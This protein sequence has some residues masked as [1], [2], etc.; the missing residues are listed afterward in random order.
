MGFPLLDRT[1]KER[2]VAKVWAG[3]LERAAEDESQERVA[4]E[5]IGGHQRVPGKE[6]NSAEWGS[7][8]L[9]CRSS[10]RG[11]RHQKTWC[12]F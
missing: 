4:G 2:V 7:F 10:D 5:E 8:R 9:Q 3:D 1:G 12:N 6:G 11:S